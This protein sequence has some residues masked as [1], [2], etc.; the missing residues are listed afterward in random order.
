MQHLERVYR[1]M[2]AFW[3]ASNQTLLCS[4]VTATSVPYIGTYRCSFILNFKLGNKKIVW[5]D[6]IGWVQQM[7]E[8]R[9]LSSRQKLAQEWTLWIGALSINNQQF[10]LP[11]SRPS[12]PTFVSKIEGNA[13]LQT[14]P[15]I[16]ASLMSSTVANAE[17]FLPFILN[18][19]N[20]I[21][22]GQL[23]LFS[24]NCIPYWN[25]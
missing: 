16:V 21:S 14:A 11:A 23:I 25:L 5:D 22:S 8:A 7:V 3:N 19:D 4:D 1:S 18:M 13:S 17:H 24:A 6:Q 20:L 9:T 2:N 12:H 15:F 10:P